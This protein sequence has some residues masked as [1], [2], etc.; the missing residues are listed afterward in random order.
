MD[1]GEEIIY[2]RT[3]AMKE[4][5]IEVSK[6]IKDLN[7]TH[8]QNDK[9]VKVMTELQTLTERDMF[10]QGVEMF[11]NVLEKMESPEFTN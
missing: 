1:E 9:L 11:L 5:L 8:E 4:K 7:I 10:L 6:M 2:T 3:D